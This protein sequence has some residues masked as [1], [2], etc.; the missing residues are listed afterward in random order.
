MELKT[1]I[2]KAEENLDIFAI[3]EAKPKNTKVP[4]N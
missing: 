4:W 2:Y 1:A 3:Q